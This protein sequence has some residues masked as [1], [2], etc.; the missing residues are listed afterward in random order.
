MST[1]KGFETS[2][3]L[4]GLVLTICLSLSTW[5]LKEVY[6]LNARLATLEANKPEVV[7]ARVNLSITELKERIKDLERRP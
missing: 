4:I 3:V 7:E 5:I 1:A 2:K 6:N